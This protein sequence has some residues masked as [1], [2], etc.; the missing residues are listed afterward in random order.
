MLKRVKPS[1]LVTGVGF[2]VGAL[3]ACNGA[4]KAQDPSLSDPETAHY[5]LSTNIDGGN[6]QKLGVAWEFS[7][8]VVR[9]QTSR[10]MEA[11]PI[12]EDGIMYMSGPWS[13]V[14]AL[15]ARSGKQLW[16]YDPEVDGQYARRAC[17]DAVNRGV[18][19]HDG[20][21]YVG[22]LDGY[23]IAVDA[24]SGKE[25]WKV[26]TF[27]D[28]K[29]SYTSTGAPRVAGKNVLI[30][31]AGAEMGVRGYTSAYDLK[32][33]KLA[34]RFFSVPGDPKGG[35]EHPEMT[36]A[37]KTWDPNSAWH[38]GGGGTV[39]DSII[40]DAETN[41]AFI[42]TGNGSPH[43]IWS[44]SPNGGDNLFLASI[45][46]V[47]ADTGKMKWYY[48]TTPG[49]SWD[50][51]A[52]QNMILADLK[53][54]GR[55]RKVIMQAP[56]NA[57]FYVL[58]RLTG[59]L[60]SAEKYS[61]ATWA[62]RIDK[63]TGRPVLTAQSDFSKAPKYI[64]PSEVGAHGWQ[65]MAYSPTTKLA[66]IPV[67]ELPS[68]FSMT[69]H[70]P[71][72]YTNVQGNGAAK[73]PYTEAEA[74]LLAGWPQPVGPEGRG[75]TILKAWDPVAN[76]EVWASKPS[77]FFGGGIATTA[78]GLVIQG[79]N[80]GYLRI[81]EGRTGKQLH[82]IYLGT[83]VGASP[84]V[85]TIDGEDYVAVTAGLG[86]SMGHPF[87]VGSAARE[88][89]NK[90]RLIVF[91][92]GGAKVALPPL[93]QASPLI[94]APAKYRGTPQQ[95]ALGA[96]LYARTCRGCHSTAAAIGG[97]PNLWKMTPETHDAFNSIVLDGAYSYAG[98]ASFSDILSK[99]DVEAIHA[100]LADP[101]SAAQ[102]GKSK[103]LTH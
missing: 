60:I 100:Y 16:Q 92:L 31:N 99:K 58:D 18:A 1:F 82:E 2:A 46:A 81:Y 12:V 97:Y 57:F 41:T 79:S 29:Q 22:S 21:V 20:V 51:T 3:L 98:M 86:G 53:I 48:Q 93:R 67:F 45:V 9:G 15:D 32:T 85:Y 75:H 4:T 11:T 63:K 49:D 40:Y 101:K 89:V 90:E 35:D 66:Y 30:G 73:P 94:A 65:P 103:Q 102:A 77:P 95:V 19:V 23:M 56:K 76:K 87:P 44:R 24:K 13:V 34:W 47:D 69:N 52:T 10:A 42:G 88:R 61:I 43:P 83:G 7:D 78:S 33:G 64:W 28:R 68:I 80:S 39:W 5:S 96:D 74:P 26:D 50:Y 8:F 14:Y 17:C 59:E 70:A 38:L 62:E 72:Q 27:I 91:K 54:D 25:L 71:R 37:R 55:D 6:V 84:L 36:L